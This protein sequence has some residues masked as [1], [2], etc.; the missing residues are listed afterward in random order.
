[1]RGGCEELTRRGRGR[2]HGAKTS[3]PRRGK[4]R[5]VGGRGVVL[6]ADWRGVGLWRHVRRTEASARPV[7][8]RSGSVR[9]PRSRAHG[10]LQR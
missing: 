9:V 8:R 10:N 5:E 2:R 4:C 3:A 6:V 1:M 7:G